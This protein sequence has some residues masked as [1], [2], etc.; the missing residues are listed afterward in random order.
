[1]RYGHGERHRLFSYHLLL[2]W[3]WRSKV[4][5]LNISENNRM[6]FHEISGKFRVRWGQSYLM[7]FARW[8]L[9]FLECI[10]TFDW[11]GKGVYSYRHSHPDKNSLKQRL[12][13]KCAWWTRRQWARLQGTKT[14]Q[15]MI[16]KGERQQENGQ[17]TI[18]LLACFCWDSPLLCWAPPLLGSSVEMLDQTSSAGENCS[19]WKKSPASGCGLNVDVFLHGFPLCNLKFVPRPCGNAQK[20][21]KNIF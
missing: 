15:T 19:S 13:W 3:A 7:K 20:T 17:V 10:E 4:H 12:Q 9:F 14:C 2:L 21:R 11:F 6:K 5:V 18:V 16:Q 8:L 1:M